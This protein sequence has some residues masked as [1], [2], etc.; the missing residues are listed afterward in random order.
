[1]YVCMYASSLQ[2]YLTA[3]CPR[4]PFIHPGEER[5]SGVKFLV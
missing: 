3:V 2:V 4:Y 1:M 5:Q